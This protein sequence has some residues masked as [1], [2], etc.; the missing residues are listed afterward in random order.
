MKCPARIKWCNISMCVPA[1]Y[2]DI[3]RRF[4][5]LRGSGGIEDEAASSYLSGSFAHSTLGWDELL[6]ERLVVVLGEPG[7]GKSWEFRRRCASLK[8]AGKPAFLI[9]LER[10]VSGVFESGLSPADLARFQ[11]W[12]RGRDTACFF[13]DSVDEAKIR[14]QSDFYAALDK[15]V[16][17]IGPAAIDRVHVFIS[18]RISEWQ[19]ET[20]LHEVL[21][22]FGAARRPG[23]PIEEAPLL[24]VRIEPLDRERVRTFAERRG[25]GNSDLFVEELDNRFAWEFARRPLDVLDLA[26]FWRAN[27]RLG[28]LTEIIEHDV[29][30]KLRE[31]TQ[32]HTH[33]P[34]SEE[35]ARE[36]AE[37]LAV[38]T[39]LCKR[40]QFKVPDDT[41]KAPDALDAASCLPADWVPAQVDALLSRPL[42]DSAT[43]G[44]I[45]FHHRRVAEYLAACWFRRRMAEGCPTH[46]LC[47][48]LFEEVRGTPVPRRSLIPVIAWLCDGNERWN[49]EVRARVV[50][51]A[52][53]IHLEYG[54]AERLPLDFKRMLLAAWIDRNKDREGVWTRYSADALRRLADPQLVPDVERFLGNGVTSGDVR[55][56]L[57]QLVRHGRL[58]QCVPN[59]VAILGNPAESDDVRLYALVALRDMGTPESYQQAW[60][61]V[62][63]MPAL[64]RL[65]C[66]VACETLYP[67]TIGAADLAMLLEKPC[68]TKDNVGNLQHT[69]QRH[70]EEHLTP[71]RAGALIGELNRL[72]Q[73]PPHIMMSNK[74]TRISVRFDFLLDVLPLVLTRL[75]SSATL[76]EAECWAAAESLSLLAESRPFHRPHADHFDSL[77]GVTRA[78]PS[79]RRCFFW[80][81]LERLRDANGAAPS[82]YLLMRDFRSVMRPAEPDVEW[83]IGD[84]E[85]S[86]NQGDRQLLLTIV[87]QHP[88]RRLMARLEQAVGSDPKLSAML[89]ADRSANRLAWFH[90][91]RYRWGNTADWEH[92]WFMKRVA[93]GRRRAALCDWW[94]LFWNR[95]RLR[96]GRAI[97]TLARLC[98]EATRNGSKRAPTSWKGLADKRGAGVAEAVKAGCKRAWRDYSP[99]L[100]HEKPCPNEVE[101]GLVVG[102]A[103]I[104]SMIADR[105]LAFGSI[106][107][108]EARLIARYA[109]N[110]MN[111]FPTWFHELAAARPGPVAEILKEC[112]LGEWQYP[113]SREYAYDVLADLAWEGQHLARLVRSTVMD[114][115][116]TG[117]PAHPAIRDAAVTLVVKTAT[118]PDDDLGRIAAARCRELPLDS[119]A[120]PLWSAVC[121]QVNANEAVTILEERL[122]GCPTADDIV[123]TICEM[124]DG[125]VR[126][127]LS[128]I[129]HPDFLRPS[130]LV[131]LIP[132]V[133]RHIRPAEDIDRSDGGPYSATPRD[134]ASRFRNGLL[135]R[136]A[137]SDDPAATA[138]LR[139]L[140][141]RAELSAQRDWIL[142]LIDERV[143]SDADERPW[144]P[145]GI[146][147]F[148]QEYETDPRTDA[149]LFRIILNRLTDIKNDVEKSDNSLREEVPPKCEESVLRRW[150]DRKLTERSRQRYTVPQEGEIDR[151]QRPDLRAE[152]PRTSSVSI[153]IKWADKWTI[154]EL[155]S[156]LETQLVGQYLRAHNSRYG[157]YVLGMGTRKRHWQHST[158]GNLTF[159]QVQALIEDRARELTAIRGDIADVR[160]VAVDFRPPPG[161]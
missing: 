147:M 155:L 44:Q 29:T 90:R 14:R 50:N 38:A 81:T 74:E 32:R 68:L 55:E 118:L 18:S 104:Q 87:L 132:L 96:S 145:A 149:E 11:Q 42:F 134:N 157:I 20:D 45:R 102:L 10:L 114:S 21:T 88:P 51:G 75:L 79:V 69:V 138:S 73:L 16:S 5:A 154:D 161:R 1:G 99:P 49:V 110:E 52:P 53:D 156:G 86:Q 94:W 111:G 43:Y 17:A 67:N 8:E 101:S 57:V 70:L 98:M 146:R 41:F 54:D 76:S 127:H 30:R 130:A 100:P 136:L 22:R 122:P 126:R 123:V 116:R 3:N 15:A 148:A 159:V 37:A 92:W 135:T 84:I 4:C 28:T 27:G 106:S 160:V 128:L 124:L 125:D 137:N 112:V 31:T 140:S 60:D 33:F 19:P 113:P 115:L 158:Q 131:R 36:G 25:I 152:N 93:M 63:A 89:R 24:V 39:I 108:K 56:L 62:R 6:K 142:H 119:A 107:D 85:I 7:S 91:L 153:E 151:K 64:P 23:S 35:K 13:L 9:E 77:D 97:G 40:H 103:G 26:E 117:D 143:V 2:I 80:Q 71:E 129:A 133:Y 144:D 78:H 82:L 58:V 139:D 120:F 61:I 83:M 46:V 65:L 12:Q 66:S 48:Q 59:L 109:V 72:V 95:G 141:V 47:Q 150:L 121:L 105:E 34:L